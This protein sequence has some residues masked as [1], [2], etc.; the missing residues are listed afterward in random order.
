MIDRLYLIRRRGLMVNRTPNSACE[1][2]SRLCGADRR[3]RLYCGADKEGPLSRSGKLVYT[4]FRQRKLR[5]AGEVPPSLLL[6]LVCTLPALT[7]DCLEGLVESRHV[8]RALKGKVYT[9]SIHRDIHSTRSALI[10]GQYCHFNALQ[11][12]PIRH[13]HSSLLSSSPSDRLEYLLDVAGLCM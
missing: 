7:V 5:Y 13:T 1:R 6:C 2:L 12:K 10:T 8:K 4:Q 3:I 11:Y 9:W